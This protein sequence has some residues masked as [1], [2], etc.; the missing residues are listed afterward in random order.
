MIKKIIIKA[1]CTVLALGVAVVSAV[2]F[3]SIGACG[4]EVK[5]DIGEWWVTTYH[6]SDNTPRGSHATSTG[7]Y[8]TEYH[9]AA[10]DMHNPLVPYGTVIEVEG[11][12]RWVVED[13]GNFGYCNNGRRALDLF[14]PEGEGGLWERRVWLIRQETP[15]EKAERL[16]RE[17]EKKEKVEKEKRE[18]IQQGEF[19]LEFDPTL[20]PWQIRTHRDAIKGGTVRIDTDGLTDFV[21]FDVKGT[22]LGDD[23]IIYVGDKQLVMMNPVVTLSE[24]VEEAVG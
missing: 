19:R 22:E 7:A 15:D 18:T 11:L 5:E 13:C 12:G 2:I 24:V 3:L 9:T 1:A 17:A 14:F 6:A 20:A 23:A 4:K 16:E 10:V 21:W 8:A